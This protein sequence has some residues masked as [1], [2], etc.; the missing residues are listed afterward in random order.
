MAEP[1]HNE[2]PASTDVVIVGAGIVGLCTA[3]Y[4]L[5]EG[6]KVVILDK[7]EAWGDASG[8]N[9]GTLSV[10][11]KHPR[12]WALTRLGIDLWE[13]LDEELG[14]VLGFHRTGSLRVATTEAGK[15]R[16]AQAVSEQNLDK[17]AV[18]YLDT[19]TLHDRHSYIGEDVV[20]AAYA[21]VDGFS[22]PLQTGGALI[23]A[24][25]RSGASVVSHAEVVAIERRDDGYRARTRRGDVSAGGIVIAA[26]AWSDRVAAMLGVELPMSVD[27]NML[28]IT[29]PLQPFLDKIITHVD[30]T[31]SLKQYP[32]GTCMIGGGWQGRGNVELGERELDYQNLLH[33]FRLAAKVLPRLRSARL[34]RMWS[35]YE[36][37]APD[38]LPV[39]G[40]LP[41]IPNAWIAAAARGGYSQGPAQG[42][43][44]AALIASGTAR[45]SLDAFDPGRFRVLVTT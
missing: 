15:Q 44:L 32:N 13:A 41:E 31:L 7:G 20:A 40:Q 38:A 4:L 33:N 39:L 25:V 17:L 27:V 34:V 28:S 16:L 45:M 3:W 37:V 10:Q 30:G 12:V 21:D 22:L 5:K 26:G 43:L 9:A 8:A 2:L 29:E 11:T 23:D 14:G 42:A 35:G 24:V 6:I 1:R 36:A 19:P 18:E